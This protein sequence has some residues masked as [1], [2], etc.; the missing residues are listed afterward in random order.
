M[1]SYWHLLMNC[2]FF[3]FKSYFRIGKCYVFFFPIFFD[4]I[5]NTTFTDI[6]VTFEWKYTILQ[7]VPKRWDQSFASLVFCFKTVCF[8]I[9]IF[10]LQV[11]WSLTRFLIVIYNINRFEM[12]FT[13]GSLH[14][15]SC[16]N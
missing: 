8:V 16:P 4:K 13:S 15:L 2:I 11:N 5:E 3:S 10:C 6:E 12:R 7:N 9:I 1:P 14:F